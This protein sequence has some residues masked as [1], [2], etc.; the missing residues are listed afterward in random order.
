MFWNLC[1]AVRCA[2]A[3]QLLTFLGMVHIAFQPLVINYFLFSEQLSVTHL[4]L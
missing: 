2:Q 1:P 4:L 3:N